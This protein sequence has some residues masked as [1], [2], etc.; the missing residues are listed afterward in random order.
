MARAVGKGSN[1]VLLPQT[2]TTIGSQELVLLICTSCLSLACPPL[3]CGVGSSGSES[4]GTD[5]FPKGSITPW[6]SF[7]VCLSFSIWET[8]RE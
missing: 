4:E 2:L 8:G 1:S 3:Y 5:L 7:L 6:A